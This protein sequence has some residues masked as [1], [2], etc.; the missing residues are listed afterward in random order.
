MKGLEEKGLDGL[1]EKQRERRRKIESVT[2]M[3][4]NSTSDN[5]GLIYCERS[6][7]LEKNLKMSCCQWI[8]H[9]FAENLRSKNKVAPIKI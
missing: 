5:G 1:Y 6:E 4:K 7:L 2:D 8:S 3:S 9:Y